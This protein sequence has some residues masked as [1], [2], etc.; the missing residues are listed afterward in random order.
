MC[1]HGV[2]LDID[3]LAGCSLM[4][5]V[6]VDFFVRVQDATLGSYRGYR[7]VTKVPTR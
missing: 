4:H 3:K 5:G 7:L 2:F 6:L 1:T